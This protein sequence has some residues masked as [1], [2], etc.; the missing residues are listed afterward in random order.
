MNTKPNFAILRVGALS[1]E[2]RGVGS[3][4]GALRHLDRHEH[5][6]EIS[7]PNLSQYNRSFCKETPTYKQ[8]IRVAKVYKQRHNEAI[9]KWNE[10]HEKQKRHLRNGAKQFFEVVFTFSPEAEKEIN[11][12][13]WARSVVDFINDEYTGKGCFPLRCCLHCDEATCHIH[14]VGVLWNKE[15]QRT[16]QNAILGNHSDLS[17]LQDRYAKKMEPFGLA[18]GHSRYNEYEAIK[19]RATAKGYEA[20]PEGVRDFAKTEGIEIPKKRNHKSIRQWKAEL[21]REGIIIEHELEAKEKQ[22]ETIKKLINEEME[23]PLFREEY[24]K[25]LENSEDLEKF[26]KKAEEITVKVNGEPST[27]ADIINS[28]IEEERQQYQSKNRDK[29]DEFCLSR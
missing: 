26:K 24:F 18:R 20:T 12:G 15:E 14:F 17:K 5:A 22:L 2:S 10:T 1:S 4:G 28:Q 16:G 8:S 13:E 25:V 29:G 23:D 3:I 27:L 7:R 21:N 11:R 19:K 6:A 9:D